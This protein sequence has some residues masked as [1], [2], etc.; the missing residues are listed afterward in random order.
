MTVRAKMNKNK[1]AAIGG[2]KQN[3]RRVGKIKLKPYGV[4]WAAGN[5]IH[6]ANTPMMDDKNI[7]KLAARKE[8][9]IWPQ[10]SRYTEKT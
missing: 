3:R 7:D 1:R 8:D 4:Y 5:R 2:E 9:L 10:H 6:T